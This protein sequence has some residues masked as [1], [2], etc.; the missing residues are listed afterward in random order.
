MDENCLSESL[1]GCCCE[2]GLRDND[3]TC[4]KGLYIVKEHG[5]CQG[6]KRNRDKKTDGDNRHPS[7]HEFLKGGKV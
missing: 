3:E 6:F 7:V 4:C 1:D 2:C 5:Y